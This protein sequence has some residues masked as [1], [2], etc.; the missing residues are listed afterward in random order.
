MISTVSDKVE[1]T[2]NAAL[3]AL[4]RDILRP[5]H[6]SMEFTGEEKYQ[7]LCT[8]DVVRGMVAARLLS[9]SLTHPM[10]KDEVRDL[11]NQMLDAMAHLYP[12]LGLSTTHM[13]A[14]EELGKMSSVSAWK[15][16]TRML[17]LFKPG[18]KKERAFTIPFLP[19]GLYK[20]A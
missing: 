13:E 18:E 2:F 4:T 15:I 19:A 3:E 12:A 16:H 6:P 20:A 14:V 10:H 7:L 11:A 1:A 9:E 5:A 8:R 17:N